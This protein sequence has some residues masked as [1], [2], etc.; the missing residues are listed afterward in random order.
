M[1]VTQQPPGKA[2][3]RDPAGPRLVRTDDGRLTLPNRWDIPVDICAGADVPIEPG[4]VDEILTVL[5]TAD[6]LVRLAAA[7]WHDGATIDRVVLTPD[8]HGR[9]RL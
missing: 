8:L 1:P 3:E 5:E 7:T 9:Y 4:A 6:T 2:L